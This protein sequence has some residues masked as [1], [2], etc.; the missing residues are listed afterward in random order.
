[1]PQTVGEKQLFD[2]GCRL[3][4]RYIDEFKFLSQNY[5]PNEISVRSTNVKRCIRSATCLLAGLYLNSMHID[6]N[7]LIII[8]IFNFFK[9]HLIR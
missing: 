8:E 2:L 5:D 7:G 1:M 6:N 4:R 3:R 9:I